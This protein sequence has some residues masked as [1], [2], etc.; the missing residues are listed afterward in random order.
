MRVL[1]W[2]MHIKK[3]VGGGYD[4]MSDNSI[5]LFVS[6]KK[7]GRHHYPKSCPGAGCFLWSTGAA[8][9]FCQQLQ[10]PK[11]Y[12]LDSTV[13]ILKIIIYN[14][15]HRVYFFTRSHRLT[16]KHF[17]S[18]LLL[19]LVCITVALHDLQS[20]TTRIDIILGASPHSDIVSKKLFPPFSF[21]LS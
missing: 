10:N 15:N 7:R 3:G 18:F 1:V 21:P 11:K 2:L 9:S 6:G 5:N 16:W 12:I 4:G 14:S 20:K 19:L 13:R 8:S 17:L